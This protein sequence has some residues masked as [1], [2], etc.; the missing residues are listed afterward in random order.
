MLNRMRSCGTA[1]MVAVLSFLGLGALR[2][3]H[4][5]PPWQATLRIAAAADLG[6]V[7]PPL[8][9]RFERQTGI[10]AEASYQS[11]AALTMQMLNGA[12]FDLFLS[13]DL[14]YP[15]RIV[16]AGLAV[17][18]API[19]YAR[20]TL[21]L[22]TRHDSR[23]PVPKL[24]TLRDPALRRLAIANPDRAPYG[25]AALAALTSLG[26]LEA[27]KPRLVTAENIA[28]AA[29]FAETGNAAAGLISLTAA[30]TPALRSAGSYFVIPG[31]LYPPI[32]QGAVVLAKSPQR[33]NAQRLL[34]FLLSPE[35]QRQL[36]LSGLQ[37]V[38]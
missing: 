38:R 33:Q 4:A 28:Q 16:A 1:A 30:L 31:N 13:A 21:V 7:L 5:Q 25:R 35:M 37:P 27:L 20:G 23:W 22:F 29:Q 17:S 14:S 8:L 11:S 34:D 36:A 24:D 10:H 3:A 2:F 26:L 12:P 15:Q 32:T 19:P 9:D 6:P 18:A